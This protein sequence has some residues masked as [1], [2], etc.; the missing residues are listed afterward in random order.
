MGCGRGIGYSSF[1][2]DYLY[3]EFEIS[4]KEIQWCDRN[5][6]NT[7]HKH[8][9]RDI[10]LFP[11]KEEYDLVFC[12]GTIENVYDMNELIRSMA[13]CSKRYL[14]NTTFK[15]YFPDLEMHEYV[16][17]PTYK[18]YNNSLSI[19][20]ARKVLINLGFREV[21]IFPE[22]T[23]KRDILFKTVIIASR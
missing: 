9:C 15:G 22:E 8:V 7:K 4:P 14:Y 18:S 6:A 19:K 2:K 10:I 23:S 16:W 21:D 12:Q 13:K 20:E 1:L 5:K 11:L 17:N 3:T